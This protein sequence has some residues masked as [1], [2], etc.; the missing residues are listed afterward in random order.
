MNA[1]NILHRH[2]LKR[3]GCREGILDIIIKASNPLS[4]NEIR[5]RLPIT[6][7]RTTF[8]RS[9]KTLL[10]HNIL[11]KIVVDNQLVKFGIGYSG[12]RDN[13][14]AHFYCT[15]CKNVK[16]MDPVSINLSFLPEGY[17][18]QETEIIMKGLCPECQ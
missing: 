16:C 3:T 13:N 4:E 5:E 15:T 12:N 2:N 11:H 6:F 9:F 17:Q 18:L 14:H 8:Y 1:E 7:D 10:E